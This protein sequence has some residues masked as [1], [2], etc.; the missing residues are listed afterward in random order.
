MTF[1]G[2]AGE[3]Q[4]ISVTSNG[5]TTIEAN[6]TFT[7]TLGTVGGTTPVQAAAITT[8]AVGTG[9][10]TNDDSETL[11]IDSPSILE[12]NAGTTTLTFTVTSPSAV[13]GGFTVAYSTARRSTRLDT[14]YT[15]QTY[16]VTCASTAGETQTISVTINGDTT[17]EANETFTVTLGTV[18]GTTPVQAASITTGAP[19]TGTLFPYTTLFRS[20]DSPSILEGNAGTTTLT[21]T[22][23]SPSV[24]QGG[25]TVAYS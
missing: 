16:A 17:I 11:T 4:T 15:A 25:F 12:G 21:F 19:P 23:T 10:I 20:I 8:G 9:T 5:D 24:V 7:V 6:E 2:T 18:G 22:V 13:Q 3:T 1:A 14:S